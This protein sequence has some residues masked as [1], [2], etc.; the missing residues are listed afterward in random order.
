MKPSELRS[1]KISEGIFE[2]QEL[3]LFSTEKEKSSVIFAR[4]G[5]GKSTIARSLNIPQINTIFYDKDHN[6]SQEGIENSYVFNEDFIRENIYLKS[7]GIKSLLIMGDDIEVEK[8]IEESE[9][10]KKN[11]EKLLQITVNEKDKNSKEIENL[12]S[13]IKKILKT[14]WPIWG[15][16]IKREGRKLSVSEK[17]IKMIENL[18]LEL[19]FEKIKIKYDE[20][21]KKYSNNLYLDKKME[22][23]YLNFTEQELINKI[24]IAVDKQK[25]IK[26]DERL[27][28][29]NSLKSLQKL[30]SS[31]I[32]FCPTCLQKIDDE[33]K[34]KMLEVVNE[35]LKDDLLKQIKIDL[36]EYD[37]KLD[38]LVKHLK[39][40]LDLSQE[41]NFLTKSKNVASKANDILTY[42]KKIIDL[43]NE[44]IENPYKAICYTSFNLEDNIELLNDYI[45]EFRDEQ[46]EYNK[47][48]ISKEEII[49]LNNKLA[50][51]EI[52]NELNIRKDKTKKKREIENKLIE[53][54]EDL[55]K[56]DDKLL[57]LRAKKA[58]KEKG[59]REIN[60]DLSYIFYSN[61]RLKVSLENEEYVISSRGKNVT[62]KDI[63]IGERNIIALVYF[64]NSLKN[65]KNIKNY[66]SNEFLLVLD[67]PISSFD[68]GNRVG[69]LSYIKLKLK[70]I[71]KGNEKSR[72]VIL[73]HDMDVARDACTILQN[74]GNVDFQ[75]LENKELRKLNPRRIDNRYKQHLTDVY[76]F[77]FEDGNQNLEDSIGNIMRKV[78]EAFCTFSYNMGIDSILE[79]EN[80]MGRFNPKEK[81]YFEGSIFRLINNYESHEENLIKNEKMTLPDI[82]SYEEKKKLAR[83]LLALIYGLNSSHLESYLKND[84]NKIQNI[85]NYKE[86]NVGY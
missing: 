12:N 41:Y 71:S 7:E 40:V 18:P 74:I 29:S 56:L 83:D 33:Y 30:F 4:N 59:I 57:E 10:K 52:E 53:L 58:H 60:E 8:K 77:A 50:R 46:Q 80:I 44:K 86:N 26:Y 15:K 5:Q 24:S 27:K 43:I 69:I 19:S 6:E 16:E 45:Q 75:K 55:K 37:N 23:I 66:S 62:P 34:N 13:S 25:N 72:F 28:Q 76:N 36:K 68:I 17:N 73:T 65:N 82:Y 39:N 64:F 78:L 48:L 67:D 21:F 61:N 14:G 63:S 11:L 42:S 84:S 51:A 22:F 70:E 31:N 1:V 2:G 3:E 32:E 9:S 38:L 79:N 35:K 20:K 54:N 49:N 85:K 81:R 47:K